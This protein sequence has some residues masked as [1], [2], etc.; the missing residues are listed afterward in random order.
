MMLRDVVVLHCRQLPYASEE[1]DVVAPRVLLL[2]DATL[3]RR[4]A[5][6]NS[7][8]YFTLFVLLIR[9]MTR[10]ANKILRHV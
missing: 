2:I 9:L 6:S 7:A 5:T 8:S 1:A 3:P 4:H 10:V